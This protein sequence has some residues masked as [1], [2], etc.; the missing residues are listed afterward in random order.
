MPTTPSRG[1]GR[2]RPQN[3]ILCPNDG[4]QKTLLITEQ[5]RYSVRATESPEPA[6]VAL[7][8]T[9]NQTFEVTRYETIR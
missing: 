5:G 9:P 1:D 7:R 8:I 3:P 4:Q 6:P 2:A